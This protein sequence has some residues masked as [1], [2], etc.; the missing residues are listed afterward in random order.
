M[1]LIAQGQNMLNNDMTKHYPAFQ[2]GADKQMPMNVIR[3]RSAVKEYKTLPMNTVTYDMSGLG[4]KRAKGFSGMQEQFSLG[5]LYETKT[6]TFDHIERK[7]YHA[8][9]KEARIPNF[10]TVREV[11]MAAKFQK[12]KDDPLSKYGSMQ[13]LVDDLSMQDINRFQFRRNFS[14]EPGL[15]TQRVGN[16]YERP[17]TTFVNPDGSVTKE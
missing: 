12:A 11:V 10:D 1:A 9:G 14:T 5:N 3:D 2:P 13:E 15:D 16:Q 4:D 8:D 17:K 6:L 7:M